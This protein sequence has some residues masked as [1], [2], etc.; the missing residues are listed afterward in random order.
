MDNT[1]A[2]VNR[3]THP[4]MEK[5]LRLKT[6]FFTFMKKDNTFG[7]HRVKPISDHQQVYLFPLD[8]YATI[9][10]NPG[11]HSDDSRDGD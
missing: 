1:K 11:G 8:F 7:N 10:L 2:E 4:E 6:F 3:Q 5:Q 9:N